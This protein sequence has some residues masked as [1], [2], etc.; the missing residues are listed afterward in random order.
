[1]DQLWEMGCNGGVAVRIGGGE[2]GLQTAKGLTAIG[3]GMCRLQQGGC[4][5]LVRIAAA[6]LL[7]W[8]L[9]PEP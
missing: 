2:Y 6:V 1:M 3:W 9:D 4:H 5:H 7:S 8:S